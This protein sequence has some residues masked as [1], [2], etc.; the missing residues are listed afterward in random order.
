MAS[1]PWVFY[2]NAKEE[3]LRGDLDLD[4]GT[5]EFVPV[6]ATYTPA[7]SH[8]SADVLTGREILDGTDSIRATL[9]NS[10]VTGANNAGAWRVTWTGDDVVIT[11]T[12]PVD[13]KYVVMLS[14]TTPIAYFETDVDLPDGVRIT[15]LT[16]TFPN[17]ILRAQ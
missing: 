15:Q 7:L 9:E 6:A 3:L 4:G 1:G 13:V 12:T 5:I 11:S 2:N 8:A 14:G 16:I 10:T 17:G